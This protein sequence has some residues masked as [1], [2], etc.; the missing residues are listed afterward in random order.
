MRGARYA[1]RNFTA[2]AVREHLRSQI[3]DSD[4]PPVLTENEIELVRFIRGGSFDWDTVLDREL[5]RTDDGTPSPSPV[6]RPADAGP[7]DADP[8]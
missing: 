1:M 5:E 7:D 3:E 4:G 8:G 2:S 6:E